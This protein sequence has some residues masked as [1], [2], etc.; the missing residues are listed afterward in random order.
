MYIQ[1]QTHNNIYNITT[2]WDKGDILKCNIKTVVIMTLYTLYIY[3]HIV[4][5]VAI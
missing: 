1:L 4:A 5:F 2:H 3:E